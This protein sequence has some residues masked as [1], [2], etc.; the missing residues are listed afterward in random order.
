MVAEVKAAYIRLDA[1]KGH[2]VTLEVVNS[3]VAMCT[4]ALSSPDA[5][6][7]FCAAI[8]SVCYKTVDSTTCRTAGV[9]PA[10]VAAMTAHRAGSTRVASYGCATLG[11]LANDNEANADAIVLSA[12]GLDAILVA[13]ATHPDN[14]TV[15][16]MACFSLRN[17]AMFCGPAGMR[18][19]QESNA[20]ALVRAAKAN[21]AGNRDVNRIADFTL[22]E[23][24]KDKL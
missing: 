8:S 21:H 15:Q 19:I 1:V 7:A 4:S 20:T 23:L 3:L 22:A 24:S 18:V 5:A 16:D 2:V 10:V 9:I 13:M 11:N 17:L 14:W 12:G 6:E